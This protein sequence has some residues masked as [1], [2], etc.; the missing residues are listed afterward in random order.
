MSNNF[1]KGCAFVMCWVPLSGVSVDSGGPN[2]YNENRF[3]NVIKVLY[4]SLF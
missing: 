1:P 2:G 3:N 4:G